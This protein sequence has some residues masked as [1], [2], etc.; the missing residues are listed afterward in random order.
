MALVDLIKAASKWVRP[1]GNIDVMS[2]RA[3]TDSTKPS[4][5]KQTLCYLW[6]E[7]QWQLREAA[8]YVCQRECSRN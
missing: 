3:N 4:S 2:V 1:S 6:L 8:F 5:E 7:V